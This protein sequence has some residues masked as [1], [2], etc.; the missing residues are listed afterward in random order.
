[1][2]NNL[3]IGI[4]THN[5]EDRIEKTLQSCEGITNN[6]LIIDDYSND[7]TVFICNKY[8]CKIIQNKFINFSQQRNYLISFC[9]TEWV[10]MLDSDEIISKTLHKSIMSKLF[11][12]NKFNSYKI[13]RI[14]YFNDYKLHIFQ[15]DYQERVF[16]TSCKPY[17]KGIVHNSL[18]I[19]GNVGY[20][21]GHINHYSFKNI[22]HYIYKIVEQSKKMAI[23]KKNEG[24]TYNFCLLIFNCIFTFIKFYIFQ[25]GFLDGI[26]G[27][28][29]SFGSVLY[30]ILTQYYMFI[31]T[32]TV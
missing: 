24:K 12:L 23:R 9:K 6:I 13:K 32:K 11:D 18:I 22:E 4:I 25:L 7:N 5:E 29:F 31:D 3:T 10:F 1:M 17:Y 30:K 28:L 21:N 15:P 20:L 26:Y 16:R 8:K 14:T 2:I 27:L 19:K